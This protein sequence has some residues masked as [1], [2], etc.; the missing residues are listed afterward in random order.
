MAQ[1]INDGSLQDA[2][3]ATPSAVGQKLL[4]LEATRRGWLVCV[5]DVSTAFLHTPLGNERIYVRPPP[6]IRQGGKI[7]R[8]S[9]AL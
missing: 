5:G 2:F 9:K 3:A 8:L 7:W 1:Q 6:N 4:L